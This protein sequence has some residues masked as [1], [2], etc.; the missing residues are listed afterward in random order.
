MKILSINGYY[1]N[2]LFIVFVINIILLIS[3]KNVYCDRSAM[4]QPNGE[5]LPHVRLAKDLLDKK[6][7]DKRVRPV[8]DQKN[9]TKVSFTMSLYQILAINDKQQSLD[10]NVWIIQKWTDEFLGWNPNKYG[11]INTTILPFESIWLPDTY[12]YNSVV[13][14]RQETERY[15]NV[16]VNTNY[17][18]KRKGADITFMYPALYRT[19]C[20]LNIKYFPYDQQYCTIIISSWTSDKASIDYY[21]ESDIVNLQNYIPN[22]EWIVVSFEIKRVEQKFVCC[23]QPWVLLECNLIIRRKPLYYIVN[24]VIPTSIITLV[25]VT[26]FFTPASTSNERR[27]KLS[28]G[29]DA[30]LAMSILMMMVSEQM[31]TT[32]DYIPLFGLFYLAIIII[33]FVGTIFTAFI[34][35][36]HLQKQYN[37]PISPLIAYIFFHK[38]AVWLKLEPSYSLSELWRETGAQYGINK[39]N[40]IKWLQI[41]K[42]KEEFRKRCNKDKFNNIN[43]ENITNYTKPKNLSTVKLVN[44]QIPL[45]D[46]DNSI[47]DISISNDV[48]KE[49]E[50]KSNSNARLNWQKLALKVCKNDNYMNSQNNIPE[51]KYQINDTIISNDYKEKEDNSSYK[52]LPIT[53]LSIF[54]SESSYK[55]KGKIYCDADEIDQKLRRRYSLEW[56]FLAA[57]VDRILLIVFSILVIVV[58]VLMVCIGEAIHMSY[59]HQDMINAMNNNSSLNN[60]VMI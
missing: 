28:L 10:L 15:I 42:R 34:L 54:N 16:V 31:P 29:I 23:P 12:V 37:R 52:D 38:V 2:C 57:I 35:N 6:R 1:Y 17:W 51:Y 36:I 55:K 27:E 32:S 44:M 3:I 46:N 13:M 53:A 30:L 39:I 56:E 9:S 40:K 60:N 45:I 25:A 7:Y 41:K 33:I 4:L 20:H 8:I 48:T 22:E 47:N 58:T 59:A 21:P 11:Q 50:F 49:L 5:F 18:N 26:G 43:I 19:T 14:N 24:L